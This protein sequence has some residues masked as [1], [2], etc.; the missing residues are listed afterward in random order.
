VVAAFVV[1]F[2][3]TSV[4]AGTGLVL[5]STLSLV[6][7]APIVLGLISP[8]MLM[9][10]PIAMRFYWRQWDSRQLRLLVPSTT[11]GILAGTWALTLLSEAWLRRTI[12]L[13]ALALALL[14]LAV[15]GRE[16][17]LFG[18]RPHWLVGVIVGAVTGIASIVAHSGG[19]VSA[20][21]LLG[22]GL[23][24]APLIAT[25]NAVYATTNLIKVILYWKIGFLTGQALLLDVF[26]LPI[27]LL[28]AW[29]GYGLNRMLPRRAFELTLLV[30]AIAGAI[31]L[32]F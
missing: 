11:L 9:S 31:R 1:G 28:G 6:L 15:T 26:A 16:R 14:Q 10:D 2:L 3:K 20:L 5:T 29:L 30:I 22:A 23:A 12:G 13:I 17:P 8:L 7:P 19:V 27:V 18:E 24:P 4:S 21:Y 32:I 25:V